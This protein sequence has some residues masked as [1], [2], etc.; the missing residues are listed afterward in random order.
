MVEVEIKTPRFEHEKIV[1]FYSFKEI[2]FV[3][4]VKINTINGNEKETELQIEYIKNVLNYSL[5]QTN[6]NYLQ[7]IEK[8]IKLLENHEPNK[9]FQNLNFNTNLNKADIE[10]LKKFYKPMDSPLCL[11]FLI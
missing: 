1:C 7:T 4:N 3:F 10:F 5:N 8:N 11:N 2:K 6:E 9:F